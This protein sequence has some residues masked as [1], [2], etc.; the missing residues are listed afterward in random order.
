VIANLNLASQPFRNRTLPWTVTIIVTAASLLALIF[1][2]RASVQANAQADAVA[3]DVNGLKQQYTA[4]QKKGSEIDAALTPEQKQ[5]LEAA[6]QLDDRKRFSWSRLFADLESV[7][8]SDARI[9]RIAVRDVAFSGDR[10]VAEL[11]LTVVGKN[12]TDVI[13]MISEMNRG[14]VFQAQPQSQNQLKS[15]NETGT[16]W[17]IGVRYTPRSAGSEVGAARGDH[18]AATSLA[19]AGDGGAR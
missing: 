16:E 2:V 13:S 6:H 3:R 15:R 19:A 7:L 4:L 18:V 12:P 5:I 9:T 8:P 10:A 1:I 11:D 14:G 17:T